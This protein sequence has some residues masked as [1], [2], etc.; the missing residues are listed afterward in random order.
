MNLHNIEAFLA[1]SETGS[2]TSAA[3]R[4]DKTQSAVS[5]AI[6]QLEIE[7]G[8]VLIDRT[9]RHIALTPAGDLLLSRAVNLM[10]DVK[11][12]KALVR[13]QSGIRVTQLRI[14]MVESFATAVGPTLIRRML[15]EALNLT[16]WSDLTPRL[17][18]ALVE[19]RVD[20][21]VINSA[22]DTEP[23]VMRFELLRE[24][25]M[26]L[27]PAG[28]PWDPDN[29]D[30]VMLSRALPMIRYEALSHL[31]AQ[32]DAQCRRLNVSPS[33][34]V[35]VD[36]TEKLIAAVAAGVGWSIG[37]PLSLLRC[38][39]YSASIRVA[40]FPGTSF[41][42]NLYMVSR[43]GELDEIVLRLARLSATVLGELVSGDLRTLLPQIYSQIIVPDAATLSAN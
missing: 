39:Q 41:H 32:I 24:P 42:R 31:A 2:F 4:L 37:T 13:E 15:D 19:K 6:R 28:A 27:L 34:R 3:R 20:I 29:P 40:P 8:A 30:L 9:S 17:V 26:L 11:K 7:F 38:P 25:F 1:V 36:S 23:H 10:D 43:R 18:E 5:Q 35:S 21:V 33:R 22:L 16:L 12:M 14:G